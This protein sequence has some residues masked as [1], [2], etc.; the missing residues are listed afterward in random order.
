VCPAIHALAVDLDIG[1]GPERP[2]IL[3]LL[4][5]S[6][7]TGPLATGPLQAPMSE[8]IIRPDASARTPG[9]R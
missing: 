1:T 3:M 7:A 4:A 5:Q 8:S 2:R 6:L 9:Q